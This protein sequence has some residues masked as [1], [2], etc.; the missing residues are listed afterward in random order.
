MISCLTVFMQKTL[1]ILQSFHS[2]SESVKVYHSSLNKVRD[3]PKVGEFFYACNTGFTE[4]L[5]KG[6]YILGR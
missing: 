5:L 4:C 3:S 6:S 1:K 2:L